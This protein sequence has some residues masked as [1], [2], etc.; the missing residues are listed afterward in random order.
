MRKGRLSKKLAPKLKKLV[1]NNTNLEVK[2]KK[3][4]LD[5]PKKP[6]PSI[7]YGLKVKNQTIRVLLDSGSS[8]TSLM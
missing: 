1:L 5:C 7:S 4:R 3:T 6:D 2:C 8:G